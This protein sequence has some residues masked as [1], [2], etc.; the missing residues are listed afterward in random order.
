MQDC[1]Q[2]A[3][4]NDRGGKTGY[5]TPRLHQKLLMG[6][7]SQAD[8]AHPIWSYSAVL[9]RVN[10]KR[11]PR[12]QAGMQVHLL[13]EH[14]CKGASKVGCT[15]VGT[16]RDK[17]CRVTRPKGASPL[18]AE[19]S[20]GV[21]PASANW[22]WSQA[23]AIATIHKLQHRLL[24]R[25]SQGEDALLY[26]TGLTHHPSLQLAG[27]QKWPSEQMRVLLG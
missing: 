12:R 14:N 22:Y 18:R 20:T 27:L 9:G 25:S 7:T 8:A 16:Q 13:L 10:A 23:E 11:A 3:V 6:R 4:C 2:P 17:A 26:T 19:S 1:L 15:D 21:N 24:V 5:R